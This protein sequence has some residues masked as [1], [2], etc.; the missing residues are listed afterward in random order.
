MEFHFERLTVWQ[1]SMKLV[2]MI[3][4]ETKRFPREERFGL[5]DQV[6][7]ASVSIPAN[8]AEGK[9][10]YHQKEF[11]QFLYI[12]RGSLYETI[13]LIKTSASLRYLQMAQQ[14]ELLKQCQVILSQL[15]GLINSLK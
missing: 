5:I 8:I 15:S 13:T 12:A 1:E 3:Y 2:S 7:R 14:E 10:R 11:L 6:R 4:S 9:G